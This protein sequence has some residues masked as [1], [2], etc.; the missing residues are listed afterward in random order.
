MTSRVAFLHHLLQIFVQ[1]SWTE[2]S[3][4]GLDASSKTMV[5]SICY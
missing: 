5:A 2:V 1:I 3:M 4:V